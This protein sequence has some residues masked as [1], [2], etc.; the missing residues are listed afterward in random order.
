MLFEVSWE[1]CNKIGGIHTVVGTKALTAIEQFGDDHYIVIGPDLTRENDNPE[2]EED[3]NLLKAWRQIA[4]AEGLR[5]RVGR[6]KTVKGTP[7]A[8]LVNFSAIMGQKDQ[9]LAKLWED[10]K[11][12][13]ISG[14]W[15]YVEPV[16]FGWAAG[17]VIESYVKYHNEPGKHAAAH[18]HEWMTASGGLYL[19]KE[20]PSIATVFTTHA[21]VIGR[22]IAGNGLPLYSGL[23]SFNGDD[24][25]RQFGVTAKH[26]I[27]KSAAHSMDAFSTVSEITKRECKA[28]LDADVSVVTPNGFEDG[29]VW[30]GQEAEDKKREARDLMIRVAEATLGI[31]LQNDPLIVSI[32]GR[33][34]FKNKGIDE[35]IDSLGELNNNDGLQR[36]ILAYIM[37]PC[38]NHG[39]RRDLQ[40]ILS[41]DKECCMDYAG[42]L[43]TTHYLGDPDNDPVV[44]HLRARGLLGKGNRVHTV[45]VP[46]YLNGD[47]GIFNKTYYE[48]LV[49][50]DVT[51]FPSYYEPWGYTPLE[52]IAFS[53]PTVTT[54]LAGFGLWVQQHSEGGHEGVTVVHR[55]DT[56]SPEVVAAI[57]QTLTE[58]ANMGDDD[59]R[60]RRESAREISKT[61]LWSNLFTYYLDLYQ[62][63]LQAALRRSARTYTDGGA[64]HEQLNYMRQQ[65]L[66][67]SKPNWTRMMVESSVPERLHPLE[68]LTKNLWWSW[69]DPARQLFES[70]D[71][72]LWNKVDRNPIDLIDQLNLKKLRELTENEEFLGRMD[73][74]YAEFQKYMAAK[75]KDARPKIAYFSMEYGL[76]HTLKIYSGGLGILAGDYLKE[77]SDK[78]VPMT[79]VGLLYRYGYFTQ[80]LSAAG[81]QEASYEPQDFFKLPISPVRDAQG[82]WKTVTVNFPGR[83]VIA[84]IWRCDVGRT[85]LYL[86]D[87]DHDLNQPEDRSVTHHLYGG[88][89][90]NRLKQ[91]FLLGIGGIR[92][93]NTLGIESD[94]YHCNEGHAAF[95][96]LERV[97]N[98]IAKYDLS[99]SEAMECVRSSSLFTTH[100]PVPAGHD[101]FPEDMIRQYMSHYPDRL[102]ITWE[103]FINLGKTNP[104]DLG[105]KFSMSVLA[106]NMSQEVNGV[107]WLHG[108]VSK[109][110]LKNIWP[111]YLPCELHIGYVTNGVHFPTW[112]ATRLKEMYYNAFGESFRNGDYSK[113]NWEKVYNID[114]KVLWDARL[115]LKERLMK[116][117]RT[118]VADPVQ[119]R[120]DSPRQIVQI[121]ESLKN[122][123]LTIGFARRF[124]TYKRAHLLFTNMERLERIVNNPERPVQFVFAGKA[125]PADKAGQDLIKKIVEVSKMPQFLGKVIFLQNYDMELARRMVQ[126]VDV[127]MN[128]PTRPLEASGT[129]GEKAVMNGV[130]HFSVL[131]GWWVEGY[132]EGAGW[133]LPME[134]TFDDPRYQ[135][136]M[137]AEMIYATIEEQIAPLYYDRDENNLPTRWVAAVKKCIAEVASQFTTNRMMQDYEDRFYSKLFARH[138]KMVADDF[139]QAREIAAWK[140]RVS[141]SWDK[142]QVLN[143]QQYD[144][145]HTAIKLGEHYNLEVNVDIDGLMPEDIGVEVLVA[146]QITDDGRNNG[147]INLKSTH[148]FELVEVEG[149]VA[150]F[151]LKSTP[152]NAGSYDVA[153]RVYAK[154]PKL[155]HRMDFALVKWV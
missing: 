41:G 61:A 1:V 152:E 16:L 131:D 4:Y 57:A 31:Q 27:E 69:Y 60:K 125:H 84:R 56:N 14:Q 73:A 76:H 45:F 132:K 112:A 34:E 151:R 53:V 74:V 58:Y 136:E 62:V 40:G 49:G 128:T 140:R 5:I 119:F 147:K 85:E 65:L 20:R 6:W 149:S 120:F 148:Q 106:S 37:V 105:E 10:Y 98:L 18:F 75:P 93:L 137:D 77:S 83:K 30:Q 133:M 33:Y 70:I 66:L 17:K 21:T 47:D 95:I 42:S 39:P 68:A 87:T 143:F 117:I 101:A 145:G 99:F 109:E 71:P 26:S 139:A 91:E 54:D 89:W 107:S 97:H 80:R 127:W 52:S 126:G 43:N 81:D 104:N 2:F 124:A 96:G 135:D 78:N 113:E 51:V 103:Q 154:N 7:V 79:A 15:D 122:D 100:T 153:I 19:Q 12:D 67:E 50:M 108:E 111:G 72:E 129:S 3:P 144:V 9:I 90:E 86:M 102:K 8:V 24:L 32:G 121:Q 138:E 94:I 114:D 64:T 28:L 88:D 25:A 141:R 11:V 92:L 13:S 36:D 38:W 130:L 142:V 63:A 150:T 134:S 48:L 55:D 59:M 82:N 115:Y 46:S 23:D 118:R 155:P 44:N 22:S 146:E 123:V 116:K 35:F 29:F 110:I